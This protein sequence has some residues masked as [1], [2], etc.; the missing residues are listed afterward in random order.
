MDK[1]RLQKI[2][3]NYCSYWKGTEDEEDQRLV[4]KMNSAEA[5]TGQRP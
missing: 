2:L 3:L 4:G 1:N 5:V